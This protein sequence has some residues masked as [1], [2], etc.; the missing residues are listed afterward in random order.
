MLSTTIYILLCGIG[1]GIFL[2]CLHMRITEHREEKRRDARSLVWLQETIRF[3]SN[4][5]GY[6]VSFNGGENWFV[7]SEE[8]RRRR[9][10]FEKQLENTGIK[11]GSL[12]WYEKSYIHNP[13]CNVML[14]I[15]YD[16]ASI[17]GRQSWLAIGPGG[18]ILGDA[19]D[20]YPE[21]VRFNKSID[22]LMKEA[23]ENGPLTELNPQQIAT[24]QEAGFTVKARN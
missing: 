7:L 12:E 1:S 10:A 9:I 16:I 15:N 21:V 8:A 22:T 23:E 13:G 19:E 5:Q 17:D 18:K 6:K 20:I 3:E 2:I 24:L 11:P 14:G 4:A